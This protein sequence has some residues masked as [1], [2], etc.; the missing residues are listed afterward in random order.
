MAESGIAR[1][2]TLNSF[3]S[4]LS[5]SKFQAVADDAAAGG[6]SAAVS[7]AASNVSVVGSTDGRR[8]ASLMESPLE[9]VLQHPATSS[10]V[11]FDNAA[12]RAARDCNSR[13]ST[14][15]S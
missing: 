12:T 15:Q 8:L 1:F 3:V 10:P 2:N 6:G 4:W 9:Q 13:S 11:M 7:D 5:A 14:G